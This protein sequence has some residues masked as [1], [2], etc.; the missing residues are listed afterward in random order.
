L[1]K[2]NGFDYKDIAILMRVNSLSFA[3]EQALLSYN[4]PYRVYGGFKF[5]ER[6]EIKNVLS[7]LRLFVNPQDEVSLLRIINFPKRGIGE[8]AVAKLQ[9]A[10]SQA[11]TSILQVI[12][13][14]EQH[15]LP[16]ALHVKLAG[17]ERIFKSLLADYET[18]PLEEFCNQVVS[19]FD[20]KSAYD[21]TIEEEQFKQMNIDTLL[22]S[23]SDFAKANNGY[24]LGQYLESVTLMS[25]ID[26]MDTSNVVTVATVHS[27]KGLEFPVVFVVGCEEGIFPISRAFN[28]GAEME[29]E[30][31]LMYVAI[32]RAE[33]KLFLTH[34]TSRYMYGRRQ[35]SVVSRFLKEM[36]YKQKFK[37][38]V[39]DMFVPKA[40]TFTPLNTIAKQVFAKPETQNTSQKDI[41]H[42]KVGQKVV[43]TRYGLGTITAIVGQDADIVFDTV[44]KKTLILTLA[45]LEIVE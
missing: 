18:M 45:P 39:E 34:A 16:A 31:R 8:A 1:T 26:N 32:T 38:P 2:Q 29:E 10:A 14:H 4:I 41:S 5:Y 7:Y 35:Y 30:R 36:G 19:R 33:Q 24:G 27:V 6:Q 43:H 25:D 44:G 22:H 9:E 17:F 11:R 3:F 40:P 23:I 21:S 15:D 37:T 42:F 28:S 13:E 20:I 12:L